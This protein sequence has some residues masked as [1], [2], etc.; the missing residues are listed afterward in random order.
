[1]EP[2]Y[3]ILLVNLP[4][5]QIQTTKIEHAQILTMDETDE[6]DTHADFARKLLG[7]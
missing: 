5:D 2:E 3:L 7:G 4:R 1:M 6:L